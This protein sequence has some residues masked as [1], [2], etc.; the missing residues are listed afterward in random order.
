[1]ARKT[2]SQILSEKRKQQEVE[3]GRLYRAMGI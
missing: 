3:L 1:M 2:Q